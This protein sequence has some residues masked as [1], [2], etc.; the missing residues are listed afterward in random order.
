M[1]RRPSPGETDEDLLKQEEELV[2]R[3]KLQPS[4]K[5]V[6]ADKRKTEDSANKDTP[7]SKFAQDRTNKKKKEGI[8]DQTILQESIRNVPRAAVL[9]RVVER[10]TALHPSPPT[11]WSPQPSPHGFPQPAILKSLTSDAG[12][13]SEVA[14]GKGRVKKSLYMRELERQGLAGKGRTAAAAASSPSAVP[15]HDPSIAALGT[16]SVI[17]RGDDVLRSKSEVDEIHQENLT[18]LSSM[19][20]EER[21]KEKEELLSCLSEDQIAFLRSLRSGGGKTAR[22]GSGVEQGVVSMEVEGERREE[23]GR[24]KEEK[25]DRNNDVEMK[26]ETEGRE[27]HSM[28]Q[29]GKTVR[30]K[31]MDEETE[32]KTKEESEETPMPAELPI[33]PEEARKWLHMD[34]VELDKLKWMTDMP[35]PKPLKDTEGFVA[36]FNFEG[37]VLP[38]SADI[39][40]R[41]GLHHHGEEPGRP[42]YSLDEI[43]LMVRSQVLQQRH[44]GLR[45]LANIFRNAKEGLY[46]QCTSPPLVQLAVE[47][48]A[49]LLLRFALDDPSHLVYSEAVRGLHHLV[50]SEPDELCL[51]LAQPW[52]P[53][54]LEPGVASEVHASEKTRQELDKEEQDLKDH[55]VIKL[56]VVRALVRMDTLVRIRYLLEKSHPGAE[57]VIHALGLLTRLARHS[58]SAAWSLASTPRLLTVILDSFLPHNVSPLLSG[59]TVASMTSVYGVPLRHALHLLRVLA[60]KGRQLASQLVNTHQLMD[61]LLVYVAMEPSEVSL[62]LQEAL[63]LS[64]EAYAT[65]AVLLAYGL[66][67]PVEAVA[68][69]YPMF[70]RQL[71]FYRDKVPLNQE[72]EN[73]KFNY[74]VGAHMLATLSR[75]VEVA[76]THSLL[77]ARARLNQGT[78]AEADGKMLVLQPPP[79]TWTHLQDLPQLVETCL[80]K[81]MSQLARGDSQPTFSGLRLVGSCCLFLV[82]YYTRWRD[83]TSYHHEECLSRIEHLH[84]SIISPFLGSPAFT[85]LLGALPAHSSLCSTLP[86]GTS[87]DPIN[88]GSLGCVTLGG[89]VVPV[90]QPLSPFPILTPLSSLLLT[91]ATLHPGLRRP[92]PDPFLESTEIASY[93]EKLCVSPRSLA[94][95]W[96]TRAET[97]FLCNML[98]LASVSE[99]VGSVRKVLFHEAALCVLLCV[100]KGDEHLVKALLTKVVCAPEFTGDLAEMTRGLDDMSLTDYEPLKSPALRQPALN[101]FQMTRNA[102]QSLSSIGSELSSVLVTRKELEASAVLTGGVPFATNSI[103][104]AHLETPLILDQFWPLMP[105]KH[106]FR[107]R[108]KPLKGQEEEE[109][110]QSKPE[111]VLTVTRCLQ[112][113]YV[114]LKHRPR[115]LLPPA[116]TSHPAWLQHLSLAFLSASDLF[117]DPAISSYLQ[118]C[119]VEILGKG[120]Y[121][122]MDLQ[123]PIDCFSSTAGWYRALVD[124]YMAVS[125]GDSTFA[126]FLV[127][128]LQQHCTKEFRTSLWGDA[129]DTLQFVYLTPEQVKRFIPLEQFLEPPEEDE[130]L[131]TR[132]RAALG[133]G[134]ISARRNPLMHAIAEHHTRRFLHHS[135]EER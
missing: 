111:D 105:L 2:A 115:I 45:M 102:L 93:L 103:T 123:R 120:G 83:Q 71:V 55:E 18:R 13:G 79:L 15:L 73:N 10:T 75:A 118:G 76:A 43:F 30:F 42:G 107:A 64:Q 88:L 128:P 22:G 29:E 14:A 117:L 74:D 33:S 92:T 100:H 9:G 46:D 89:K 16:S 108:Q 90:I 86:P 129:S 31:D 37:D 49:V 121:A 77:E 26:E 4:V 62:P 36:R 112:M 59:Q 28:P 32:T 50:A 132:Y 82:T 126:L 130:G 134:T 119:V 131:I 21:M 34:K 95:Q 40:Y 85:K 53:G 94:S 106:A 61:R 80:A 52:T 7:K 27:S 56:D 47:A 97:Y 24:L 65:W 96:L 98:Q 114:G 58:L 23:E 5:L 127:T 116:T 122:K 125:Y 38:Y 6:K 54:G 70:V 1:L 69:F 48:G 39:S 67:K 113:A 87:R 81:W 60:A 72:Q 99:G 19:S 8:K 135:K 17:I 110:N 57:T 3:G 124:Q 12:E 51:S 41:Q 25:A 66:S 63:L 101:P 44:Q 68:S 78:V 84:H 109:S 91:L 35:P 104:V 11:Q 133:T 20:H